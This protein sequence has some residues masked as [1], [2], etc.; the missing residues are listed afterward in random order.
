MLTKIINNLPK[1]SSGYILLFLSILCIGFFNE[2]RCEESGKAYV[3][4][5][6]CRE[7]H[8]TEYTSFITFAKKRHSFESV[9]I[10]KKGLTA[11][12]LRQCFTCHTT[13]YG[14]PGGFRSETETPHLKNAGCEVCHGPGSLH[15]ETEDPKDIKWQL[16]AKD[17]EV[18]HSS[19]RVEAFSYKPLIYG[20]AH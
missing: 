4:S 3:G 18:C 2:V 6:S 19:E 7:C 13:G 9:M 10:M 20:G 15:A 11:T 12:E 5:E 17:C 16:T 1:F 14:E 8:E